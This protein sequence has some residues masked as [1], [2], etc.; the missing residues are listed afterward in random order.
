MNSLDQRENVIGKMFEKVSSPFGKDQDCEIVRDGSELTCEAIRPT[1]GKV[2]WF[3]RRKINAMLPTAR[4][5]CSLC[6]RSEATRPRWPRVPPK[7]RP[8]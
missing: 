4:S 3:V 1:F 2:I 8:R 6:Q 5:E 7:G